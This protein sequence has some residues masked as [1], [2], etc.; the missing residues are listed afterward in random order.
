MSVKSNPKIDPKTLENVVSEAARPFVLDEDALRALTRALSPERL[1][2]YLGETGGDLRR[3]LGLHVW[4][5]AL[6]AAFLGPLQALEVTVRNALERELA[7]AYGPAW[8]DAP[9]CPLSPLARTIV[10]E[11]KSQLLAQGAP[12]DAPHVIA[13]L[14]FGFWVALLERRAEMVLWRPT[15]HRAFPHARLARAPVHQRLD[16]LRRLRN[17]IVHH[18][19]IFRRHLRADHRS[20]LRV[21]G[22]IEPRVGEWIAHHSRVD[23]VLLG[24]DG[25][26]D[27]RF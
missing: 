5:T 9:R 25:E 3:A 20:L 15:L 17:R 18:E 6:G 11:A 24:G 22:W 1:T 12:I 14:S 7:R 4:N 8:F 21:A 27:A 19:P 2:T 10:A 23:T 26:T 13:G 16:H